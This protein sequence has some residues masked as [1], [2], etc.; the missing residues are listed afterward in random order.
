M[1]ITSEE[2]FVSRHSKHNTLIFLVATGIYTVAYT[3]GEHTVLLPNLV[4]RLGAPAWLITFPLVGSITICRLPQFFI[5]WFLRPEISRKKNFVN[6]IK[7]VGND[8]KE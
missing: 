8:G 2:Q 4:H 3:F 1:D 7:E 5:A 6:P